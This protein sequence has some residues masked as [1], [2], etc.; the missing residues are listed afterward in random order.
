MSPPLCS[1]GAQRTE[2]GALTLMLINKQPATATSTTVL[3]SNVLHVGV[4]RV[5]QLATNTIVHL[6]DLAVWT[7]RLTLA[8]PA[9]SITLLVL[10]APAQLEL[11]A[12]AAAPFA[13]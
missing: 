12:P 7:N 1:F 13:F 8:L 9:Q 11:L 2:D 5:W 6:P 4:A 10:P 3:L